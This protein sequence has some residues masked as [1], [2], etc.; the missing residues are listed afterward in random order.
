M[1]KR[2]RYRT[3]EETAALDEQIVRFL[4]E[5]H[6]QSVRHIFY[7]LTDPRL[8]VSIDK[9]ENG[10]KHVGRRCVELRRKG[11]IPYGWIS[12]ATRR[13]YHVASYDDAAD[14]LASVASLYRQRL[15]TADLPHVELWVESRSI[16]G[17]LQ[18]ECEALAVSLYPAG[19]FSSLTLCYQAAAEIDRRRR[20]HAIVLYVGD[21]DPAGVLIDGKIE[22][23]LRRHLATPMELRRLA[24]NPE[25]VA[26]YDLP[27]KPRKPSERRRP[28]LAETVEAE[29][30]P[31][32]ELRRIVRDAIKSY[33]PANALEAV[34]AAEE[35]ERADLRSLAELLRSDV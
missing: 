25:Q 34:T 23:E 31:A 35:S 15:W 32:S 18:T 11:E 5:D 7:R 6:P 20:Q 28:D 27:T 4:Q 8:P 29:A 16:A 17:V 2:G 1:A 12:D 13:G 21:H 26:Q 24:I 9:T 3:K 22:E 19:G 14:F 10:Y 30:M 33:L